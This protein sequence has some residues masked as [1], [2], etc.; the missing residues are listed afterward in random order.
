[1]QKKKYIS[2]KQCNNSFNYQIKSIQSAARFSILLL[3]TIILLVIK[4]LNHQMKASS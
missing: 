4:F 2:F 1:M 3:K